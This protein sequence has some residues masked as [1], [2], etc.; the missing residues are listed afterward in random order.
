[1]T[2]TPVSYTHLPQ[3]YITETAPAVET[4]ASESTPVAD[5]QTTEGTAPTEA[6]APETQPPA[7]RWV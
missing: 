6:P 3:D 1:M 7:P 4:Q 2:V 5:E